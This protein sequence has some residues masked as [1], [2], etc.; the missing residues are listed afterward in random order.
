MRRAKSR[1]GPCE[2]V[3]RGNQ[4][5][6]GA[7]GGLPRTGPR[8]PCASSREPRLTSAPLQMWGL[9][10]SGRRQGLRVS[11]EGSRRFSKTKSRIQFPATL[12]VP[13]TH[14][15]DP[16]GRPR[17]GVR[18]AP[19]PGLAFPVW[20]AGPGRRRGGRVGRCRCPGADKGARGAQLGPQD[21]PWPGGSGPLHPCAVFV[22]PKQVSCTNRGLDP[23]FPGLLALP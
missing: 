3:L 7:Q 4:L 9:G 18:T 23:A 5:K 12:G 11:G 13:S 14:G 1:R 10:Q 19:D 22:L 20:L 17:T 15:A 16:H 6:P 2:P 8:V 21:A